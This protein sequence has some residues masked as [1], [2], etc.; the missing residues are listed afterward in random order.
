MNPFPHVVIVPGLEYLEDTSPLL[1]TAGGRGEMESDWAALP[2][3]VLIRSTRLTAP[4]E[5][6]PPR[7]QKKKMKVFPPE[8]G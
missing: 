4:P 8:L 7:A 2:R 6:W 3:P 5:L 1:M